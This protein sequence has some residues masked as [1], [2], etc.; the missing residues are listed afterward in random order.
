[1]TPRKGKEKKKKRVCLAKL[2]SAKGKRR[3]KYSGKYH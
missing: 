3:E 2:K 1:M